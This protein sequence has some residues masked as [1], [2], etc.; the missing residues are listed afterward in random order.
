VKENGNKNIKVLSFDIE[1]TVLD[2]IK[3]GDIVATV[4]Q[5]QYNMGYWSLNF[6]Y[7]QAHG[8][9]AENLPGFLDTGVT[10]VTK[11]TV[12]NYYPK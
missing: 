7:H 12:D 1:T 11:D 6:L 10:I 2:M 9:A 3:T 5:G 8:L 4:A